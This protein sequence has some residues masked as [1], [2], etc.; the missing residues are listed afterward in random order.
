MRR[1]SVSG[2]RGI[3][4]ILRPTIYIVAI[5]VAV[6]T[7]FTEAGISNREQI[8]PQSSSCHVPVHTHSLARCSSLHAV[9][10]FSSQCLPP[11]EADEI[12]A[13]LAH[14]VKRS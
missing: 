14:G 2:G 8:S 13:T 10:V 9:S 11:C 3:A 12:K 5:L 1:S 7:L 4:S 6:D